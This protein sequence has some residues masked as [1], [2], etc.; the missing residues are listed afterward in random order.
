MEKGTKIFLG[1]S[2]TIAGLL[3]LGYLITRG[4]GPECETDADCPQGYVCVDGVCVLETPGIGE[5]VGIVTDCDSGLPIS[6]VTVTLD[7]EVSTTSNASGAFGFTNVGVGQHTICYEHAD[8]QS[9]CHVIAV[10]EGETTNASECLEPGAPPAT[11]GI[12]F[13][14]VECSEIPYVPFPYVRCYADS[15]ECTTDSYGRC[16]IE[17]LEPGVYACTCQVPAGYEPYEELPQE[18]QVVAGQIVPILIMLFPV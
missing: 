5:V 8:Y 17:D 4:E 1:V 16:I 9:E 7:A 15:H 10:R 3:G 14:V 2:S 11:G 6:G 12:H 18:V 13:K